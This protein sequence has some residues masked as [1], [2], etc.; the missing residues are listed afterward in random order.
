MRF[1]IHVIDDASQHEKIDSQFQ[2]IPG[3][4]LD[5]ATCEILRSDAFYT[6]EAETPMDAVTALSNQI[7]IKQS[8][9]DEVLLSEG[10]SQTHSSL[11]I[12]DFSGG[13]AK[14]LI[15]DSNVKVVNNAYSEFLMASCQIPME[16]GEESWVELHNVYFYVTE[17]TKIIEI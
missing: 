11:K 1:I 13:E 7:K 16:E 3:I 14:S 8:E 2:M 15:S 4:A 9:N 17:E 12:T 10:F 5:N 6:V